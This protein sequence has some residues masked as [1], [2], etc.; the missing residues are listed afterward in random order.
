MSKIIFLLFSISLLFLTVMISPA[1]ADIL[2]PKKQIAFGISADDVVCETGMF[3]VT[4]ASTNTVSCVNV[5]SVSKLVSLGWA[6]SIDQSKLDSAMSNLNLSTGTI[7]Q[8]I[9]TPIYSDFGKQSP[10]VSIS[11]YDYVFDVCATTK[12]LVSP[13]ILIRSDSETKHI[14]LAETIT[15]NSC[16]SSAIV[17]K[18]ANPN[19]IVATL[20]SKGD[21][22][23]LIL[24]L[25][26]KVDSL[27]MQL[28][29]ARTSYG[30]EATEKNMAIGEKIIDLR[31]QLN[32]AREDLHRIYFTLYTP[33]KSKFSH[34]K[35]SLSGTPIVGNSVTKLSVSPSI[36][37][38]NSYNVFFE[39]CAGNK[40]VRLPVISITSDFETNDVRLGDKIAPNTCQLSSGKITAT[41]P[42]SITVEPAGNAESST[43]A[44]DLEVI[45]TDLQKQLTSEKDL[46]KSLIHNSSRPDNFNEKVSLHVDKITQLRNDVISAKA[47]LSKLLYLTYK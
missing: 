18:A 16:V 17:I 2:P 14:E 43:R 10:K 25:S 23:Q 20:Q 34:E 24:S 1:S 40:Q 11:S 26:E 27:K 47:E 19:S 32:D 42:E 31:K 8:L 13:T 3:K 5:D 9:V 41:D 38:P 29:D 39:A 30:K 35:L 36:I 12:T 7:N 15:S 6:K 4:K 44:G 46:L 33:E 28:Q 21:V 37:S 22:S 45:I